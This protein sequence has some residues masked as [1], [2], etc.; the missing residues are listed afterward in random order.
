MTRQLAIK[1]ETSKSWFI[2]AQERLQRY[3]LPSLI[4]L[5]TDPPVTTQ[6]KRLVKNT[7]LTHWSESIIEQ[8]TQKS[9]L[10]FLQCFKSPSSAF[11]DTHALWRHVEPNTRD[12][13]CATVKARILS[14][15][16]ILQSNRDRFNG[17]VVP[18][19]CPLCGTEPEDLLHFTIR[20]PSLECRRRPYL[21]TIMNTLPATRIYPETQLLQLLLDPTHPGC[22]VHCSDISFCESISRKLFYALHSLRTSLLLP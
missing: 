9:S 5:V 2:Y 11:R 1:E 8:A 15:T 20:C 21:D 6:W 22:T 4:S 3:K 14:G 19:R 18:G 16:Y 12:V 13:R 10:R 7:I 17:S